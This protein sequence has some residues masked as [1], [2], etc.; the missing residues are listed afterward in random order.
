M[1]A[2]QALPMRACE[3][4]HLHHPDQLLWVSVGAA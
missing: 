1:G 2:Q 3:N 4:A